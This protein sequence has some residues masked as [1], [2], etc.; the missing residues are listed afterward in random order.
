MYIGRR[1]RPPSPILL[2]ILILN[3]LI[4]YLC[5]LLWCWCVETVPEVAGILRIYRYTQHP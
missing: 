2:L 5:Q 3:Y 1:R 4:T